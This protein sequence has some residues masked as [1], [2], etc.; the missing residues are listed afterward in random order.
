MKILDCVYTPLGRCT[1]LPRLALSWLDVSCITYQILDF[2]SINIKDGL[3][4]SCRLDVP[5]RFL[6]AARLYLR[7]GLLFATGASNG[8]G[9]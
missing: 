4:N 2:S 5:I 7:Q 8:S 1:K 9:I 6:S 3:I